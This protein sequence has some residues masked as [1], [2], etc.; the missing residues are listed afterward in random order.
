MKVT[1]MVSAKKTYEDGII[2]GKIQALEETQAIHTSRLDSHSERLRHMERITWL[3]LGGLA[4]LQALPIMSKVIGI[5][6]S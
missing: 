3:I 2:E 5:V 6:G 1:E 4:V